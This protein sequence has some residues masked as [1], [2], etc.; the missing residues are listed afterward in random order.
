M[1]LLT[2]DSHY[3]ADWCTYCH[4]LKALRTDDQPGDPAREDALRESFHRTRPGWR[5]AMVHGGRVARAYA[6]EWLARARR[7]KYGPP[8]GRSVYE[9]G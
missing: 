9:A 7:G 3:H 2:L 6:K 8:P 1:F 4:E 5:K